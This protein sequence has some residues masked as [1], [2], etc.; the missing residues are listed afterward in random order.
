[1]VVNLHARNSQY[2]SERSCRGSTHVDVCS[3]LDGLRH[4]LSGDIGC[5]VGTQVEK[6]NDRVEF[7]FKH[8]FSLEDAHFA[9]KNHPLKGKKSLLVDVAHYPKLDVAPFVN[10][11][12]GLIERDDFDPQFITR[13]LAQTGLFTTKSMTTGIDMLQ[14]SDAILVYPIVCQPFFQQHGIDNL[15]I[16]NSCRQK[17]RVG[18]YRLAEEEPDPHLS[19]ILDSIRCATQ[20]MRAKDYTG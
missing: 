18:I 6:L 4:L 7:L 3:S 10:Q 16:S 15:N 9:R 14:D 19:N 12:L 5:F 20:G 8:L 17:I 1:M 13:S 11:H 2:L